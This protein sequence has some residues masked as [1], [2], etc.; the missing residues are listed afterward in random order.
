MQTARG[1]VR[2]SRG[3]RGDHL[4]G[5]HR[6]A[7]RQERTDRLVRRAQRRP[8]R[9]GEDDGEH[10][11]ARDQARE[12][13]PA[14]CRGP[15]RGA[16]RSGQINSAVPRPVRGCRRLPAPYDRG[17]RRSHRPA[18]VAVGGRG[19]ARA[20]DEQGRGEHRD[21]RSAIHE[22]V[23][24]AVHEAVN[25][26]VH[27]AVLDAVHGTDRPAEHRHRADHGPNLWSTDGLWTAP[28]P[29]TA[30]VPYTSHGD[31]GHRVDFARPATTPSSGRW[32]R[33]SVP[34]GTARRG[35]RT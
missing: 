20:R 17:A 27:D 14:W 25:E 11:A 23:D 28:S 12:R 24:E 22:A 21:E 29:G 16:R 26:V 9:T 4:S 34:C 1:T 13:D 7:F 35:V 2:R 6:R 19:R 8:T 10:S 18:A 32:P 3:D 30:R 33:S 15:Y 5:A 31:P